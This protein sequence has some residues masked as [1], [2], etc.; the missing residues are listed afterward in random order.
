M[1]RASTENFNPKIVTF[2]CG[3]FIYETVF[4]LLIPRLGIGTKL[5][6]G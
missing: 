6:V 2:L 1:P 4:T 5:Q 3:S